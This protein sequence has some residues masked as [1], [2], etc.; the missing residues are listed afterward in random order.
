[1]LELQGRGGA[2]PCFLCKN[3]V[4]HRHQADGLLSV[5][6]SDYGLLDLCTDDQVYEAVDTLAAALVA[7][8][9]F[10]L[11]ERALGFTY[12]PGSLLLDA[13]IRGFLRPA[14]AHRYDPM[15]TLVGN[16]VAHFELANLFC[17]CLAKIPRFSYALIREYL[18]A[19]WVMPHHLGISM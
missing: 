1:M 11:L 15:H 18:S 3:I 10:K 14:S 12:L 13:A 6:C 9:P 4:T 5:G 16:G 7:G 8:E 17:R 2:S 19:D